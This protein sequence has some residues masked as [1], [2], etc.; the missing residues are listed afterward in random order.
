MEYD[1]VIDAETWAFIQKTTSLYPE[2][3]IGLSIAQQRRVYDDMCRH[4]HQARPDGVETEDVTADGVACRVYEAGEPYVTVIYFHG[5]GFVVGG[6]ESHDDVCAEICARTGYRV[7]SVDYRLAP[8]HVFPAAFDD[9]WAATKWVAQTY[10]GPIVLVGDSA[11]GRVAATVAHLACGRIK[12][13]FGQVLIY[14]SL[15]G[16]TDA[17]SY[18]EHAHAPLLTR[19]DVLYYEKI[20]T[21]DGRVEKDPAFT[22]LLQSDFSKLPPTVL[23]TADCDPVRDDCRNYRDRIRDAEGRVTWINEAGLV[24]GCLRAR[25]SVVRARDSF[26]RIVLAIEAL[27]QQIWPYED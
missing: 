17:G 20:T 14:P 24:H 11:G 18:I 27:G 7:V 16:D 22:P 8:E 13:I 6:L 26:D 12:Q 19:D 4:F 15:G 21:E 10:E 5:G 25:H 23:I 3:A 1:T 2:D 9:G